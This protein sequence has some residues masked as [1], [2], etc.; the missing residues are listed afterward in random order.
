[1]VEHLPF[2]EFDMAGVTNTVERLKNTGL[3]TDYSD[4]DK[5]AGIVK[6]GFE[7]P[8]TR[9]GSLVLF[10]IHKVARPGSSVI[11]LG[12]VVQLCSKLPGAEKI[13]HGCVKGVTQVGAVF[14]AEADLKQGFLSGDDLETAAAA[15]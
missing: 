15:L 13:N 6:I 2:N 1:M 8:V 3:Y 5:E 11:R 10:V 14:A 9:D 12:W 7:N 4:D